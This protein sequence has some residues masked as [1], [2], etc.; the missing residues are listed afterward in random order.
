ML[1]SPPRSAAGIAFSPMDMLTI[2]AAALKRRARLNARGENELSRLGRRGD[3]P[4][5]REGARIG[6][7][8]LRRPVQGRSV[9]EP[10]F[11]EAAF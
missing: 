4:K 5:R 10:A 1:T 2:A 6:S 8:A 3:C 9:G 11:D 7:R